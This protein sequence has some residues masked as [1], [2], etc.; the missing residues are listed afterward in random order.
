MTINPRDM[1]PDDLRSA[2]REELGGQ[3]VDEL[4]SRIE[5]ETDTD[6]EGRPVHS[7]EVK[8]LLLIE[9]GADPEDLARPYLTTIPDAYAGRLTLFEWLDFVLRRAGVSRT[10]EAIEYYENV[11]WISSDVGDGLRDHVRA[12]REVTHSGGT[13]DLTMADHVLS[14]VYIARLSSMT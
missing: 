13:T 14:L 8:E 6:E 9:S 2:A 11:G 12:F 3:D 4:K 10:L 1:D 5:T 7:D